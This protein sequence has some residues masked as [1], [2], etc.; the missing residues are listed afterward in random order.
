MRW[1]KLNDLFS[2]WR[3]IPNFMKIAAISRVFDKLMVFYM[4]HRGNKY[5][6]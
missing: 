4:K 1:E 2:W 6:L 3:A 5:V